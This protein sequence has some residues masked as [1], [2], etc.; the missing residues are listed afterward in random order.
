MTS[1]AAATAWLAAFVLPLL[2]YLPTLGY[3]FVFDDEPLIARNPALQGPLRLGAYFQLDID[4]LRLDA[5][6][7]GSSNYYRPVLMVALRAMRAVAA[8]DPRVWHALVAGLHGCVGLLAMAFL[9]TRGFGLV[10][11]LLGSLA[12]SAHPAHVDSV[13]WVAGVQDVWLG[14]TG[15]AAA[16]AWELW[17]RSPSAARGLVLGLAFALALLSKEAALGLL[18][19][20]A[21]EAA[22]ARRRQAP[23]ARAA[24]AGVLLLA[25]VATAYLALRWGVLGALARPLP[26]S[27]PLALALASLPRVTL[28]Y[29]RLA[30]VPIDLALLSPV[31]PVTSWASP[32]VLGGAAVLAGLAVGWLALAAR[33]PQVLAPGLWFA[34][35]LLPCLN[36][37]A[38]NREWL[39]MDRYLY[40]PVLA[41]PWLVLGA[42]GER[43]RRRPLVLL[44]VLACAYAG[45]SLHHMRA[46]HDERRFWA[47]MLE[48]DPRSSTALTEHARLLI[49]AGRRAE[50]RQ[51]LE[52]ATVLA[53][54]SLLPA[55]RL[56]NLDLA[57]GRPLR[58]AEGFARLTRRSPG[59]LP[60]WR[61]L[62]IAL[63]QAG[64]GEALVAAREAAARFPRDAELL[65]TLATLLRAGGQ[66]EQALAALRQARAAAPLDPRAALREVQ[67]LAELGRREEARA[68]LVAARALSSATAY[69][70]QLEALA[71][72]LR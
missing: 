10:P 45:L 47:R 31:R 54:E 59:Y 30:L 26:S 43:G 18:F 55:F 29:L 2:L 50:G 13:A 9:V 37:W 5:D 15:L 53:P 66:G 12:F 3:G 25:G 64:R 33:R 11:A 19:F 62:P 24:A 28:E 17:R 56:A 67:L 51:A 38:L 35:W 52:Q 71:L 41:L 49:E 68:A 8:A 72:L 20:A 57:E 48:A 44:A 58:A 39:V 6:R 42:P 65:V 4:A 40:L 23:D 36:L 34:A 21:G 16:L 27:P 61:N 32:E 63:H 69:Q 22:W 70:A 60:A 1:R 46:F 7:A 14:L